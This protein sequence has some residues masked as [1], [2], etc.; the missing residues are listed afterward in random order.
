MLKKKNK[1]KEVIQLVYYFFKFIFL[2]LFYK[3]LRTFNGV[4]KFIIIFFWVRKYYFLGQQIYKNFIL[5]VSQI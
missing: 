2:F 1:F 3:Y 4:Y 5:F